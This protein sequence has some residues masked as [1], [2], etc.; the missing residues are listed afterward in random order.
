MGVWTESKVT[1]SVMEENTNELQSR[2]N[3]QIRDNFRGITYLWKYNNEKCS[4]HTKKMQC[5]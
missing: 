4:I 3:G 2:I 5:F 1:G